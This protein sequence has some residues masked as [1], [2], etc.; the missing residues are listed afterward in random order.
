MTG[1]H[2]MLV[3]TALNIVYSVTDH[4][5]LHDVVYFDN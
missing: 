1:L 5:E 2:F 3:T 4:S